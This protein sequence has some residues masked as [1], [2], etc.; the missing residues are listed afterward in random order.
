MPIA[1]V[2][3]RLGLVPARCLHNNAAGEHDLGAIAGVNPGSN[4]AECHLA[5]NRSPNLNPAANCDPKSGPNNSGANHGPINGPD[6]GAN[7]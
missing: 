1:P 3:G 6:R 7:R 5:A 2:P 4:R